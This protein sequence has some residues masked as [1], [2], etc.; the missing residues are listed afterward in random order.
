[1]FVN[2][3]LRQGG[4]FDPISEEAQDVYDE[5]LADLFARMDPLAFADKLGVTQRLFAAV[6][7]YESR[8]MQMQVTHQRAH[9]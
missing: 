6:E 9:R 3:G 4:E 5:I 7:E 8:A 2:P 1:M